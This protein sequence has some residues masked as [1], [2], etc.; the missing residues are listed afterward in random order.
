MP[1][2]TVGAHYD[3]LKDN[4]DG[5]K[6]LVQSSRPCPVCLRSTAGSAV[7]PMDTDDGERLVHLTCK[8]LA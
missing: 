5:S 7:I 6:T 3:L 2:L 1:T 4:P 8:E